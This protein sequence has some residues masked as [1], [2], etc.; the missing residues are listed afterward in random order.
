MVAAINPCGFALLPAYLTVLVTRDDGDRT[1]AL[2]RALR[3]SAGMTVGFVAVFGLFGAVVAPLAVAVERYLPFV[4]VVVGIG[5]VVMGVLMLLGRTLPAPRLAIRGRGP[6]GAWLSQVSYGV[7]F[8]LASLS[9]T[10]GPFLAVT[11]TALRAGDVPAVVLTFVAYALGM[12]TVV[13]ILAV[14]AAFARGTLL[15]HARRS[16]AYVARIGGALLVVAGA[17]VTWYGIYELRVLAGRTTDDPLVD[18]VTNVQSEATRWV[19][20]LGAP[21]IAATAAVLMLG[22]VLALRRR[23]PRA[24]RK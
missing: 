16:G 3:F 2:S 23:T 15:A 5:L 17:Y 13:L 8:A 10:I 4:T 1:A 12:G 18:G 6:T 20:E 7:T 22:V 19:A 11:S 21:T 14:A 9:C 24:L